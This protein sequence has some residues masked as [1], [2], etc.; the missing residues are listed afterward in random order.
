MGPAIPE[1]TGEAGAA[2]FVGSSPSRGSSNVS[3]LRLPLLLGLLGHLKVAV[4]RGQAQPAGPCAQ[5]PAMRD[6]QAPPRPPT[7]VS[8]EPMPLKRNE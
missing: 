1:R 4:L 3:L 8:F 5:L 7:Y 2:P 6:S